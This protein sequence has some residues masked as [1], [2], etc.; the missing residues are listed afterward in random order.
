MEIS[1][2]N[3]NQTEKMSKKNLRKVKKL[4]F[5][6]EKV[7]QTA[8]VNVLDSSLWHRLKSVYLRWLQINI[9]KKGNE[10]I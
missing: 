2:R 10:K 9:E 7:K 8:K 4:R 5:T 6:I 1:Q 3:K